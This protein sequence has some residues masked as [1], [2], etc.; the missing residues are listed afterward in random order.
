MGT[1][2]QCEGEN[3]HKYKGY[4]IQPVATLRGWIATVSKPQ[5]SS[6]FHDGIRTPKWT[7]PEFPDRDSAISDAELAIDG[8]T[9]R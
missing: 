3:G 4:Y 9:V 5:G 6:I 1:F 7:T 2:M 8:R